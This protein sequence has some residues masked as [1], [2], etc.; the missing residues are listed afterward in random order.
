M[1]IL[2]DTRNAVPE[3]ASAIAEVFYQAW[4]S[5]YPNEEHGVTVDDILYRYRQRHSPTSVCRRVAE[6]KNLDTGVTMRVATHGRRVV[7]VCR[8]SHDTERN[9]L[10][11]IYLL[12]RY[13]H[14]SIGLVLFYESLLLHNESLPIVVH[15]AT[16]NM[17]A[18]SFYMKLGFVGTGRTFADP[19]FKLHS[20]AIIPKL[21]MV[22]DPRPAPS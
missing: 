10:E 7:G 18:I 2:I 11:A 4:L 14:K 9:Q 16:Y 5:T 21:E 20:G 19:K 12:P 17:A 22:L 13:T 6:Y 3:D 15:V 1:P 8:M